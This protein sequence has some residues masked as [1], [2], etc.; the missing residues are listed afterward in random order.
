MNQ[1]EVETK[2]YQ[3]RQKQV[4]ACRKDTFSVGYTSDW[5]RSWCEFL[6]QSQ[7]QLKPEN[8]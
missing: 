5:L 2:S 7:G 8:Q 1:S 4:N 6:N 3:R